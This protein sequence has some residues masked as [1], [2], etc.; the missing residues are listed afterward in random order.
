MTLAP[1]AELARPAAGRPPTLSGRDMLCFSHDWTGD[2]LSKTHLMRLLARDNRVLWVNSIGYRAPTATAGRPR[3][4]LAE[5]QGGDVPAVRKPSRTCIVLNPLAIPACGVARGPGV[6][7]QFLRW[8]VRRAMRK[9]R[10][11]RPINWVFNP[12]A[13]VLAGT[14]GEDRVIYYCVDEYTAF[15]GVPSESL[16]ELER[17][18]IR[19]ADLVDRLGRAAAPDQGAVQPADRPGPSR[20]GLRPLPRRRWT[21]PRRSRTRF[22]T[23]PA[24]HRVLR[25]D[26]AGLGRRA[27]ARGGRPPVRRRVAGPA[28]QGDDGPGRRSTRMPNVHLLGP[29]AV[30]SPARLLQGV[31]RRRD[32][33][34]DHRGDAE[35]QPAQGP[36]VPGGR[37]AGRLDRDPGG[38]GPRDVPDRPDDRRVRP[39]GSRRRWP[40]PGPSAARSDEMRTEGWR[41]RLDEVIASPGRYPGAAVVRR[42]A[43]DPGHGPDPHDPRPTCGRKARLVLRVRPLARPSSRCS[44][45]T[46]PRR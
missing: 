3:P 44:S 29:Q 14:L 43:S 25:P 7:P 15:A 24:G 10:F 1:S 21:R 34:P 45:P 36:R 27:P 19:R 38:R 17:E 5:A 18:L 28:R 37:A 4:G 11:R 9:L 2:P 6:Q 41:A 12:A 26:V 8:Q 31:R 39:R 30:R 22:A 20:G 16:V 23:A 33:V 40:R 42:R 46:A 13:A 35:R 32:P